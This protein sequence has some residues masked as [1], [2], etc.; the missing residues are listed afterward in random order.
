MK[1]FLIYT[2]RIK[3]PGLTLTKEIQGYLEAK[4]QNCS[5]CIKETDWKTTKEEMELPDQV[6][7]MLVLGGDGTVLEAARETRAKAIPFIGVN[8]GTLGYLTEIE[9]EDIYQ[10]IDRIVIGDYKQESRMLL[11]GTLQKANGEVLEG[12]ALNDMVISRAGSLQ[13]VDYRIVVNG[14]FLHEYHAD[15]V[16]VTTATGSTGYNLSAGG[17]IV[18]PS[19]QLMMLTPICPHTLNQ[20]SIVLS[21][22]DEIEIMIVAKEQGSV[23]KV[24]MA[25]DGISLGLVEAGDKVRICKAKQRAEFIALSDRSFLEILHRKMKD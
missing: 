19:A 20:R 13:V 14:Q 18:E 23:P 12:S 21:P 9:K 4:G 22:E 1:H 24:E 6:D 11:E 10:A 2:N 5:L 16:I 15:G 8:L 17:P 7:V 25:A 3:D